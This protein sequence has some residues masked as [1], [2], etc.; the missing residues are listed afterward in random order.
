MT[1][2][3]FQYKTTEVCTAANI[4]IDLL[5]TWQILR[6][7]LKDWRL[8]GIKTGAHIMDTEANE[9]SSLLYSS[10]NNGEYCFQRYINHL[11]IEASDRFRNLLLAIEVIFFLELIVTLCSASKM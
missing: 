4:F 11:I 3:Y 7:N 8:L 5:V 6:K 10:E 1:I 2:S 9:R